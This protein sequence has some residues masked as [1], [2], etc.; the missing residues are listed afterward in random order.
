VNA[1]PLTPEDRAVLALESPTVAGHTCKV[2][3]VAPPA[4]DTE[5]LRVAIGKRLDSAPALKRR[6]GD[7]DAGPAWVADDDFDIV[8]HVVGRMQARP[9]DRASLA[10][11]V[12]FLFAQ[13]LDRNRPLWRIDVLPMQ[14]GGAALVWRIHHAL[15][16][17]TTAMRYARTLLWEESQHAG[18][19]SAAPHSRHH[20]ADDLRRRAHLAAFMRRE[21]ARSRERSPFDGRIGTRRHVAFARAPLDALHDAAKRIGGATLN[22]AVLTLVT[23]GLRHWVQ[24]HH[25]RL[26]DVRVKVPVSLHNEGDDAGNRDSFFSL[27]LPLNEP[28]PATR[29]L[30]VHA[31]TAVRKAEH[32]AEAMD[33]LASRLSGLSPALERFCERLEHNPRRFAVNV[34]NVPGPRNPVTVLETPVR[35]MHSIAEIGERHALRVAVVSLAGA[36]YFGFVADPAI[37]DDLEAMAEGVEAE[38]AALVALG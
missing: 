38:A 6:L 21:F 12:A 28:D 11:E 15:A 14:D 16:D 8:R 26:G 5:V 1:L 27:G 25:G 23:G 32:D 9:L 35:S 34:S 10:E 29:L 17:G 7:A 20:A 37:V 36:L 30:A 33:E 2:I 24:E 22:D 18:A 4:P 31:A 3:V 13:R 19:S